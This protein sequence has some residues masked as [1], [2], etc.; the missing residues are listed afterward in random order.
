MSE[1]ETLVQQSAASIGRALA[2][3]DVDPVTLTRHVLKRA[4]ASRADHVFLSITEERA[5]AEANASAKRLSENRPLSPLDGVPIALKDLIDIEG[6]TTTAASDLYRHAPPAQKDAPIAANLAAAGMICIGKV[7]LTEFAY[8]GIGL[9]PHFGTPVNPY[10]KNTPR[11]PGGSSSGS[12]VAV[13]SSIVP[14]AIGSDT[15]GS[16]RIPASFNGLVG[17]KTSSGR[18][19]T[20]GVFPLSRMF[21]TIGPLARSV[22]D[23]L[24]LDMAMRGQVTS[25]VQRTSVNGLT[26]I[27]PETVVLDGLAP[28][29]SENFE[30]TLHRLEAAGAILKRRPFEIFATIVRL[31]AELGSLVAAD[32]YVEHREIVDSDR[33]NKV[34]RRVMARMLGGENMSAADVVS[35]QRARSGL[36]TEL[37]SLIGDALLAMPTTAVTAPEIAPLE[38]DDD[39]FHKTN[40]LALRNTT[41]GNFLDMPG[42]ALPNGYDENGMPTSI[43][44]SAASG[45]DDALLGFGFQLEQ[46][47][48]ALFVPAQ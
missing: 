23:C 31:T 41:L 26:V 30:A 4:E 5:M 32:A 39:L 12:A 25:P 45:Q 16:V 27:V 7:N 42:L 6:E 46:I 20:K 33:R 2:A 34:D 19:S 28:A 38:A 3:G 15:G 17:F 36:Q 21:D 37:R 1:I 24:L 10:D 48:R 35:L 13:A 29:V 14:C 18:I 22:E 44:F 11:V 47:A 8:S 40:L 43:L 9:N